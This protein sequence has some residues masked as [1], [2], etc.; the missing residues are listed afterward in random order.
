M[1]VPKRYCGGCGVRL[2]RKGERTDPKYGTPVQGPLTRALV[3]LSTGQI[4]MR[5]IC[6]SCRRD[7]I[8]NN[9]ARSTLGSYPGL[10]LV[11]AGPD[12]PDAKV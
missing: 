12:A 4:R 5:R 2:A 3:L 1:T 9:E 8:A 6:A 7:S 10:P 11:A